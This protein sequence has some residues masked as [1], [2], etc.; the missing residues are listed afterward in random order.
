MGIP[1]Y[2]VP[3]RV[4]ISHRQIP[5]DQLRHKKPKFKNGIT[6]ASML[7]IYNNT[8]NAYVIAS[9]NTYTSAY[10]SKTRQSPTPHPRVKRKLLKKSRSLFVNDVGTT[11]NAV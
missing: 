7:L 1:G 6:C 8:I 2:G 11:V 9:I 10:I 5:N 4:N 3:P